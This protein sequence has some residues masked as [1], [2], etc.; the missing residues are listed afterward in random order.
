MRGLCQGQALRAAF[1][2]REPQYMDLHLGLSSPDPGRS[3]SFAVGT[4]E[5]GAN[6]SRQNALSTWR[7]FRCPQRSL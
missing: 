5:F 7:A 6:H 2:V 4:G 3:D 1:A